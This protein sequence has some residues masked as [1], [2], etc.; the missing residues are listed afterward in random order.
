MDTPTY[1]C[2]VDST[3][4]SLVTVAL[5]SLSTIVGIIVMIC[6]SVAAYQRVNERQHA[7]S[8][9]LSRVIS[10]SKSTKTANNDTSYKNEI[11]LSIGSINS[12]NLSV[13]DSEDHQD[14]FVIKFSNNNTNQS[15]ASNTNGH[16]ERS[17]G[18][19]LRT[20]LLNVCDCNC[21]FMFKFC[22]FLPLEILR[23]KR[24]YFPIATHIIDQA[25]D[26]AVIVEFGQLHFEQDYICNDIDTLALFILSVIAFLLYRIVSAFWVY[27]ATKSCLNTFIQILDLKIFHALYI[28]FLS[29]K[30]EPNTAQKYIQILEASLESFLQ[31]IIQFYYFIKLNLNITSNYLVFTSLIFSILNVS[32]KMISEDQL[33]FVEKWQNLNF[34]CGLSRCSIKCN[35][36]HIFR[37]IVRLL[38]VTLRVLVIVTVWLVLGFWFRW[39]YILV[40][41][42]ILF[43][44]ALW[45][46]R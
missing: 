9:A 5:I 17:L 10:S 32:S 28:N 25:T 42:V 20:L 35:K 31:I 38:D 41:L 24:C 19:K 18:T 26:I 8:L 6:G 4:P 23:K 37:S 2:H 33:Y 7:A 16:D 40:E 45:S 13:S 15:N 14:E 11:E 21:D 36:W 44:V 43:A 12:L 30:H 34:R 3:L 29:N 22:Y 27:L 39:G 1:S 46:Q